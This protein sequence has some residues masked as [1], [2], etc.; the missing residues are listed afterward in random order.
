MLADDYRLSASVAFVKHFVEKY[1]T[2]FEGMTTDSSNPEIL[3]TTLANHA[4]PTKPMN[5]VAIE[6]AGDRTN[7]P[8]P[9]TRV[10]S[11]HVAN[12]SN[13]SEK[14]HTALVSATNV[15]KAKSSESQGKSASASSSG[16]KQATKSQSQQESSKNT[17][18]AKT[19]S[20]AQ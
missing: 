17:N 14:S 10:S 5:P 8:T 20:K 4:P 11:A 3:A 7:A 2:K 1:A 15:A 12:T 18:V 13:K 9:S 6:S 16:E 19:T